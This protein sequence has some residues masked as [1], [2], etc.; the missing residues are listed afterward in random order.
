MASR[1]SFF[2][3]APAFKLNSLWMNNIKLADILAINDKPLIFLSHNGEPRFSQV[4]ASN[5]RSFNLQWRLTSFQ[6]A[7]GVDSRPG[8]SAGRSQE[9]DARGSAN[10][11]L[12][13]CLPPSVL[14]IAPIPRIGPRT[15]NSASRGWPWILV[16]HCLWFVKKKI[17]L[18]INTYRIRQN[19]RNFLY[20]GNRIFR[21]IV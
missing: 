6:G 17:I 11:L 7:V 13:F 21:V 18:L 8:Q 5:T 4:L 10:R 1:A 14:W 16:K 12:A 15:F 3:P 19:I 9:S 2:A 20:K